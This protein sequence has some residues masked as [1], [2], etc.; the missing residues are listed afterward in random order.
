MVE[1]FVAPNE[2]GTLAIVVAGDVPANYEACV[3]RWLAARGTPGRVER[4]P[5]SQALE[6]LRGRHRDLV[7]FL[8]YSSDPGAEIV[9]FEPGVAVFT[10]DPPAGSRRPEPAVT[11][12]VTLVPRKGL[13]DD[14][15][16]SLTDYLV[17]VP[18]SPEDRHHKR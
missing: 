2:A 3:R 6:L 10:E 12:P 14:V 1:S 4:G 9:A 16:R 8:G 17:G 15:I 11:I 7:L 5:G 13:E 18:G